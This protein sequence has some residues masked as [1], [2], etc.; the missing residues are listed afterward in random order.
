M[1]AGLSSGR[2]SAAMA[3]GNRKGFGFVI[4]SGIGRIVRRP[5][6]ADTVARAG[7]A[8]SGETPR[9]VCWAEHPQTS[10]A[11]TRATNRGRNCVT[12]ALLVLV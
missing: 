7:A 9:P 11:A 6:S 2:I 5:G 4:T 8:V 12:T 3:S 1:V 10:A